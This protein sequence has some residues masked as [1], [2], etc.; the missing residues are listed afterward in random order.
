MRANIPDG[1]AGRVETSSVV[2]SLV[3]TALYMVHYLLLYGMTVVWTGPQ[4]LSMSCRHSSVHPVPAC[5][6]KA[7]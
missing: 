3:Q 6:R 5:K 4:I 2:S 7:D 1:R